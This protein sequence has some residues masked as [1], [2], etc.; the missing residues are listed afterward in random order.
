MSQIL[1]KRNSDISIGVIIKNA[2]MNPTIDTLLLAPVKPENADNKLVP[3]YDAE[4]VAT[5]FDTDSD[6]Y[7]KA[8][9][10]F[11]EA[12]NGRLDIVKVSNTTVQVLQATNKPA[13]PTDVNAQATN[14][15]AKVTNNLETTT[16]DVDGYVAGLIPNLYCGAKYVLMAMP[17][18][19][20]TDV[21][22]AK[23][24]KD[25]YIQSVIA[26]SNYLYDNQQTILVS[27]VDNVADLK[28]IYDAVAEKVAS[29]SKNRLGNTIIFANNNAGQF[30]EVESV[31]YAISHIPLDWM[32]IHDL[33]G[34]DSNEWTEAEYAQIMAY[35]GLTMTN[36]A[37]DIVVSNSKAVDGTYIDHT[38]GTQYITNAIQVKMQRFLTSTDYLPYDNDGIALLKAQLESVMTE[39]GAKGLLVR[40]N[41]K[42]VYSVITTSRENVAPSDYKNRIYRGTKVTCTL[43]TAIE[44]VNMTLEIT[45]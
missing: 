11:A 41:G 2:P 37:G 24:V 4:D 28:K 30:P 26:V 23:E 8:E 17:D 32:R 13:K 31:A 40:D 12:E 20:K 33:T 3:Y 22:K 7:K 36:K 21:A 27:A 43:A 19:D 38:F 42:P 9:A 39:I 45:K 35:N 1:T 16:V 25:K 10:Y 34:I 44:K 14:D 29:V 5:D 15:G 18:Y 6:V